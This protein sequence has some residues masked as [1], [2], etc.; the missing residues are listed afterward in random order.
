MF[1]Q[2]CS[3]G[4]DAAMFRLC[5]TYVLSMFNVMSSFWLS[6]VNSVYGIRS[7]IDL[8]LVIPSAVL[9]KSIS[10]VHNGYAGWLANQ[11]EN[12]KWNNK[13]NKKQ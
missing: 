3:V 11:K 9:V 8:C 10:I 12:N 4:F 5:I 2:S 13:T 7:A 6:S 1:L